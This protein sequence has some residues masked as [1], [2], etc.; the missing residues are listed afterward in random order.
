MKAIMISINPQFVEK[1]LSGEKT[2][3]Y[4]KSMFHDRSVEKLLI[5]ETK[6]VCKVVAECHIDDVLVMPKHKLWEQTNQQSGISEDF[7][8]KYFE[9]KEI[10]KAIKISNIQKY[11]NPKSLSDY[12][13]K[14]AP[15]GY[16]YVDNVEE[17]HCNC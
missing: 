5:Y 4:R 9:K 11:E 10:A 1:I 8:F 15:R 14:N 16:V 6:P 2:Y 13:L 12:G 3:E 17:N 7:F